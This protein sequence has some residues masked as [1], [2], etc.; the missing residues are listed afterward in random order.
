[1][2]R[3]TFLEISSGAL[4]TK[5]LADTPMPM[6]TLGRS[7]LRVSRLGVGGHHM[8]VHGLENG[9]RVIQRAVD[10]GVTF[11]DSAHKYSDGLSDTIYGRALT[12]GRRQKVVLMCKAHLRSRDDAMRQLEESLRRMRTD[13]LDLW[14]CHEVSTQ[15]EV[16]KILA[17]NGSLEAFVKAKEQGKTRHIGFTGH[18]DPAVHQRLLD[19]FDGWETVQHPVNLLDP[20]YLSFIDNVLPRVRAKGLGRIGMK[21]NA[22]GAIT[23]AGIASIDEC[24]RFAWS[25]DI[26][27]LISGVETVE[28]LEHNVL[29]CKT[30]QKMNAREMAE[31]LARTEKGPHGSTI[32]KY[33]KSEREPGRALHHDGNLG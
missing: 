26:H 24:L 19:A 20:H 22:I 11:F 6:S 25:Q 21:S 8:N 9:V 17:P 15:E 33:K 10:L 30:F 16:D 18:H 32:E 31:L 13:Y 1:M 27:T 4:G 28:Q 29:A 14:Q 12:G 5:A 23:K 2:D 3:R 7:G